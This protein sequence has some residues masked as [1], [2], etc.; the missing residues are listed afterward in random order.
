MNGIIPGCQG[1]G[2][3]MKKHISKHPKMKKL[4]QEFAFAKRLWKSVCFST[5][6][7]V[8]AGTKGF[9]FLRGLIRNSFVL[10]SV[11]LGS[12]PSSPWLEA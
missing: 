5:L 8:D 1:Q 6:H 4:P 10:V 7:G 3:R 9:Y 12:S 11:F 2:R